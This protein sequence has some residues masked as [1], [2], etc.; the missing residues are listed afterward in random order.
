MSSQA[1]PDTQLGLTNEEIQLLR[2]GQ[3]AL[4]GGS[5]SSRAASRA[6]SQGLLLLDSSS[7][8]AL[9]RYFDHLMAS[10]EQRI[11]YLSH[12]AQRFTQLQYDDADGIIGGADA[13]IARYTE[14][15]QQLDELE[16]DFDRIAHIKEIVKGYRSRVESLERDLE[17][18]GSSSR[19]HHSRHSSSHHSSS[20]RSHSHRQS[21]SHRSRH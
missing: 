13:E 11:N 17:S 12:E 1:V 15:L 16:V 19:H 6:S 21:S 18:S 14:I 3:A 4:G 9:G 2:Q 8:S 5:S 10:I 20:H 7:L